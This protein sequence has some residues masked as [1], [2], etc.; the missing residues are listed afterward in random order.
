MA[1]HSDHAK[2]PRR[3]RAT[4]IAKACACHGSWN[5]GPSLSRGMPGTATA[6]A[7]VAASDCAISRCSSHR[8][9]IGLES[10]DRHLYGRVGVRAP[11]IA[12]VEAHRV[13]PLRA[14]GAGRD[15]R[16][17]EHVAAV[18][19]LHG[20]GMTAHVA[21]QAGVGLRVNVPGAH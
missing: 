1:A 4:T 19:P 7:S 14:L 20:T 10:V 8:F 17:R 16:I 18:H 5:T 6:E 21:R 3:W 2:T 12:V 13:K 15:D 11:Q 9:E